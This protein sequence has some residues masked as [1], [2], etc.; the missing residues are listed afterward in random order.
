MF[1]FFSPLFRE[2]SIVARVFHYLN[3]V[4]MNSNTHNHSSSITDVS[5]VSVWHPL[6]SHYN[7]Y[8]TAFFFVFHILAEISSAVLFAANRMNTEK[9]E[10]NRLYRNIGL[11]N[12]RSMLTPFATA[13]LL[14]F[15]LDKH[16][17]KTVTIECVIFGC[18]SVKRVQSPISQEYN[19]VRC[20]KNESTSTHNGQN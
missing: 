4:Q 12:R 3:V 6:Y 18:K 17:M 16:D 11:A 14:L 20:P 10:I 1:F 13:E 8:C 19:N 5:G 9:I 7:V 15:P 2:C